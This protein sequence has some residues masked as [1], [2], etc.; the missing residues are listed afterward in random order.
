MSTGD[1]DIII[2]NTE[3]PGRST[4]TGGGQRGVR[5]LQLSVCVN[6]QKSIIIGSIN[7][8]IYILITGQHLNQPP[9]T[10]ARVYKGML[11]QVRGRICVFVCTH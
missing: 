7:S 5:L 1:N 8:K 6:V 2:T 3:E 10:K 11:R 9:T 4:Q